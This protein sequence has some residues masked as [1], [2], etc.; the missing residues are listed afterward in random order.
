[1]EFCTKNTY[2]ISFEIK[3]QN[4]SLAQKKK[5]FKKVFQNIDCLLLSV[6]PK[7]IKLKKT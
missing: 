7:K 1:M 6:W 4:Y 3:I 2:K 5:Q